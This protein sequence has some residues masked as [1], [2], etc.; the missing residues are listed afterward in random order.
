M[1]ALNL[2]SIRQRQS[3][4]F[5]SAAEVLAALSSPVRLR[6]VHLLS[7]AP[8]TV[9][10]LAQKLGES[11]ANTSMHLRK[12][13]LLGLVK[14]EVEAKHRRYL[15]HPGMFDFW[16]RAQ[17]F[18]QQFDAELFTLDASQEETIW[19]LSVKET[20][21][22][23]DAGDALLLDVRPSDESAHWQFPKKWRVLAISGHEL[24][25]RLKEIPK[26]KK[27]LVACRGRLCALGTFSVAQ[28][29]EAGFQAYRLPYSFHQL[30]PPTGGS[31]W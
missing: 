14:A 12:L 20:K 15:L 25:N 13:A 19:A 30:I 31:E 16:E 4:S 27:I 1:S 29:N 18:L 26:N 22:L 9:E 2:E 17:D 23:L 7:Q 11:V 28:L 21:A 3:E 6:L 8:Q 5:A 10:V 24:K